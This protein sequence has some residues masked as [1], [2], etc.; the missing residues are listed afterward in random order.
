MIAPIVAA[1]PTHTGLMSRVCRDASSAA[2]TSAISPGSGMPRLSIPMIRPT[3][4]YTA[5]GGMDSRIDST[6]TRQECRIDCG[7]RREPPG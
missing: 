4:T 5:S 7:C 3:T 2:L 1:A 6:F